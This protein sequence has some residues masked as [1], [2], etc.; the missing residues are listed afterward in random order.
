MFV[1]L[2]VWVEVKGLS[3]KLVDANVEKSWLSCFF[4]D[5]YCIGAVVKKVLGGQN[6]LKPLQRY[7]ATT[8]RRYNATPLYRSTANNA[9]VAESNDATPIHLFFPICLSLSLFPFSVLRIINKNLSK[10]L[11]KKVRQ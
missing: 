10:D 1:N 6:S 2:H 5:C 8:L 11:F 9:N 3:K 7:A 4:V